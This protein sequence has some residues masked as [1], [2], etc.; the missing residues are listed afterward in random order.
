MQSIRD[1]LELE[2]T[3]VADTRAKQS[4][5]VLILGRSYAQKVLSRVLG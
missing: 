3:P 2:L 5:A 1:I 4:L